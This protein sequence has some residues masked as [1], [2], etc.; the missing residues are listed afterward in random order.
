MEREIKDVLA[1][2]GGRV[3]VLDIP[4]YLGVNVEIVERAMDTFVKK[5]RVT[6]VNGALISSAYQD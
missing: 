4:Q 3:N 2:Q 6:L 1:E 5:N